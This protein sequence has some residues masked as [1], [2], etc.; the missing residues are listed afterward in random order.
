MKKILAFSGSLSRDSINH[1]LV[2]CAAD[3]M[4]N[5]KVSVVRLADFDAPLYRRELERE[6]GIP[7]SI[8]SLRL[9]FD[10]A[11]AFIIS[12]PEYNS[13]IPAGFK[14]TIDWVSRLDGKIFQDKPVVLLGTSPGARGAQSVLNHLSEVI[15]FWGAELVGTFSLPKF[16]E[17]FSDGQVSNLGL[18][19]EL[20][21]V[22]EKLST[23]LEQS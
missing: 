5:A 14:N 3:L 20:I 12:I 2:V 23:R 6:K 18:N 10:E 17:H 11:D 21:A 15:P 13:S 9:L 8:Q 16:G 4:R 1:Q 7:L 22:L 19:Q